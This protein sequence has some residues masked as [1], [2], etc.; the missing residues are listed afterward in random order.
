[1]LRYLKQSKLLLI[2]S[3]ALLAL[4]GLTTVLT[5]LVLQNVLDTAIAGNLEEFRGTIVFSVGYFIMVG[6]I[7]YL[8]MLVSTKL[9]CEVWPKASFQ[10]KSPMPKGSSLL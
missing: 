10:K 4:S 1:M 5:A 7:A 2:A 9:V 3:I 6:V 8:A